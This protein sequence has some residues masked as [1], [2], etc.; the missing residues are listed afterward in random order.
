MLNM[1][2]WSSGEIILVDVGH[3]FKLISAWV[4]TSISS[5]GENL[6]GPLFD[7]S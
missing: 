3:N 6:D 1:F 5:L 2:C 7:S 4:E